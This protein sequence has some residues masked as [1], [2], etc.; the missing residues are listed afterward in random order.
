[1]KALTELRVRRD[2]VH[3]VVR[4]E[5]AEGPGYNGG[6]RR[7]SEPARCHKA[8]VDLQ[9]R[10]AALRRLLPA[11]DVAARAVTRHDLLGLEI[12]TGVAQLCTASDPNCAV[13]I[14]AP[15]ST[16]FS[17]TD[18]REA[19][20]QYKGWSCQTSRRHSTTYIADERVVRARHEHTRTLLR[21]IAT[22]QSQ[23]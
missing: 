2:G 17:A 5:G 22:H 11:R 12:Q 3:D 21:E 4:V 19:K 6:A 16:D 8:L 15:S 10:L 14:P 13:H 7:T 20:R 1:M 9:G 23:T 18:L